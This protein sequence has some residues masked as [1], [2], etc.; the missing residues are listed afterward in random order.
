MKTLGRFFNIPTR[1]YNVM[2]FKKADED[3]LAF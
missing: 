3:E 1:N 2:T